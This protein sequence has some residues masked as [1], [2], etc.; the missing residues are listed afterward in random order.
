MIDIKKEKT[1]LRRLCKKK[2]AQIQGSE[3]EAFDKSIC[4]CIAHLPEFSSA[5]VLLA[6]YPV[7]TEINIMPL[8]S[9]AEKHGKRVAFPVCISETEMVFRYCDDI[10]SQPCGAY[11]IKEPSEGHSLYEKSSDTFCIIPALA[12][13]KNGYRTGYGRG[14]YDRFLSGYE[15]AGAAVIYSALVF[16]EIPHDCYD[17][18]IKTIITERGVLPTN[19]QEQ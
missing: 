1:A 8:V 13:D 16:D 19:E 7:S 4:A 6:Y 3:K 2:R 17:A 10:E 12:V 9:L 18:K 5:S 15:G 11:G 14:Y